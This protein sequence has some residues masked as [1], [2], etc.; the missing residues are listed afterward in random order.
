MRDSREMN[1]RVVTVASFDEPY[2]AHI[3]R[4][5]LESAGIR[6]FLSGENFVSTYWLLSRADGGIKLKV[7]QQD[8]KAAEEFLRQKKS[9]SEA[10][11]SDEA[12]GYDLV[13]PKCGSENIDYE[14]FSR[15]A[16]MLSIL[17]FR[18]PLTWLKEKYKCEDC[19]NVWE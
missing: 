16:L 11:K 13:C 3:A 8:V 14:R 12:E 7:W 18:L 6:C 9:S 1:D 10:G 4:I 17:L 19:G 15:K 2:K 5:K